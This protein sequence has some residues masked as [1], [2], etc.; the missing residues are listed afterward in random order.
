M[1]TCVGHLHQHPPKCENPFAFDPLELFAIAAY[2]ITSDRHLLAA[3]EEL[4]RDD[5]ERREREAKRDSVRESDEEEIEEE[6]EVGRRQ[7]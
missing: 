5:R 1:H 4:D 2:Q 7:V 3:Y 6:P